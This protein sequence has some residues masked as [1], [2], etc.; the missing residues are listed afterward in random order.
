[1]AC[2]GGDVDGDASG[3]AT[4]PIDDY[5]LFFHSSFVVVHSGSLSWL[6]CLYYHLVITR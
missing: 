1:M 3:M 4:T 6:T 5:L 2:K